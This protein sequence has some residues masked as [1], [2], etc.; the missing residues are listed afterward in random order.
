MVLIRSLNA[1]GKRF[2]VYVGN[3]PSAETYQVDSSLAKVGRTDTPPELGVPIRIPLVK[4][5]YVKLQA[6]AIWNYTTRGGLAEV[7]I[8]GF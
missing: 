4:G 3:D 5:R 2:K 8:L 1:V 6:T 7:Q